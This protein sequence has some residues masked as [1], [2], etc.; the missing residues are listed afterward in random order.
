MCDLLAQTEWWF[1]EDLHYLNGILEVQI[2]EGMTS[3]SSEDVP[4]ANGLSINGARPVQVTSCSRRARVIFGKVLAYQLMDESY[5]SQNRGKIKKIGGTVLCQHTASGY[6][7]YLRDSSLINV[8]VDE[9]THHFSLNL[10]DD[11]LDVITT[12]EPTVESL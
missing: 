3:A 11:I 10:A 5:D 2:A 4:I 7:E 1:L 8:M 12:M 9:T 6:T